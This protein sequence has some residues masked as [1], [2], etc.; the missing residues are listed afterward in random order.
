MDFNMPQLNIVLLRR[1]LKV[2]TA[3][4]PRHLYI[5]TGRVSG[6]KKNVQ[7]KGAVVLLAIKF[8]LFFMIGQIAV[9]PFEF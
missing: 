2:H 5:D 3:I 4:G 1:N 6:Q 7:S 9:P 8:V